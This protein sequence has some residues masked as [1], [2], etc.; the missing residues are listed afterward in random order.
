MMILALFV[1]QVSFKGGRWD[2]MVYLC[3]YAIIV[4]DVGFFQVKDWGNP[5]I[6]I[7]AGVITCHK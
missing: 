1:G 3:R 5:S 2:S 6:S 4:N 7:A